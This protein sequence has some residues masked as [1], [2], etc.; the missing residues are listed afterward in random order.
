M[1][2][3]EYKKA[4]HAHDWHYNYSDD[5]GIWQKGEREASTLSHIAKTYGE[6]FKQEYDKAIAYY[7]S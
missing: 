6:E 3:Q 4:L 1:T 7:Y 2:I 5:H